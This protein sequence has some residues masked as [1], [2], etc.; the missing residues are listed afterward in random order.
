[1]AEL[2]LDDV[3]RHPL[4]GELD[5]MRVTQLMRRKA[6]PDARLGGVPAKLAADCGGRSGSTAG[7][8]VDHAEQR[9][10]RHLNSL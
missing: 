7:W 2:A 1:V 9:A 10:R 5:G 3:Q 6:S 8:A 4:P